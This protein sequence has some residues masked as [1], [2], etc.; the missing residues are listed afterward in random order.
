M[1]K[2]PHKALL[3]GLLGGGILSIIILIGAVYQSISFA[4]DDEWP[5]FLPAI[6]QNSSAQT[7]ATSTPTMTPS[8]TPTI[9]PSPTSTATPNPHHFNS[10]VR[11][12]GNNASIVIPNSVTIVGNLTLEP[13]DEIAIFAPDGL[14]CAGTTPWD[15]NNIAITAWGDDTQT[16]AI[17]GLQ[18]GE[19][20][21]FRIWD[22]SA[23]QEIQVAEVTYSLG[24]GIYT[25]DSFHVVNSLTIEMNSYEKH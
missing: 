22:K 23:M 13:G 3:F 17:D 18:V 1:K 14:I 19:E 25:V 21:Q 5:V 9:T 4:L 24:D 20:M 11:L 12:T 7:P 15:G 8:P 16:D 6:L 10:C 2:V